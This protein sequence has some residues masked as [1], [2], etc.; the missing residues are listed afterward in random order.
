MR[1]RTRRSELALICL[2]L[3]LG[4]CATPPDPVSV[5]RDQI[6]IPYPG[7]KG[8]VYPRCAEYEADT[9]AKWDR[10]TEYLLSDAPT[11]AR[12]RAAEFVCRVG[13]DY[14]VPCEGENALCLNGDGKRPFLGIIG[15]KPTVPKGKISLET[16]Y[17]R[18]LDDRTYCRTAER[19][20]GGI[21]P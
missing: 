8:L 16:Q 21:H 20:Q 3:A 18:L 17:Q 1:S 9:C 6:L 11:R 7:R 13:R 10:S 12:L 14:Y 2:A 19:M 15:K 5:L 4:A